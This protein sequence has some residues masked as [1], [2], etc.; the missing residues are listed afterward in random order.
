MRR[1]L[2]RDVLRIALATALGLGG[3][4]RNA[5]AGPATSGTGDWQ[6]D[7]GANLDIAAIRA[8]C[9]GLVP[10]P[11]LAGTAYDSI[12]AH[13]Q[14]AARSDSILAD[15][16]RRATAAVRQ[17]FGSELPVTDGA[18]FSAFLT[19]VEHTAFFAA[20]LSALTPAVVSLSEVWDIAGY[21]G[22]SFTRGGYLLHGF[23][24]LD[25]LPEPP[26]TA[27]GALP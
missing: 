14:E 26:S 23:N 1:V 25:W 17:R 4:S 8:V 19:A 3:L 22:E 21:E 27:M 13:W 11:K 9:R 20:L 2:R 16:L 10:I 18:E 6:R 15:H 12:L 5:S 7:D 24:D